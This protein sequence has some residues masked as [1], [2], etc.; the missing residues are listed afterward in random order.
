[1]ASEV[2]IRPGHPNE[3]GTLSALME[4]AIRDG[5]P[6]YGEAERAAWLGGPQAATPRAQRIAAQFV[7][8][9]DAPGDGPVGFMTMIP[10]GEIDFAYILPRWQ[11]R[12]LFPRLYAALEA[13]ARGLGLR[14]LVVY[15]SLM[16]DGPFARAGFALEREDPVQI[17][18]VELKRWLMRKSL[19]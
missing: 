19:T 14:E 10:D 6:A 17:G 12:G 9:A 16:A 7:W 1:M 4:T 8:V 15:A 13:H 11:G 5:A 18:G 2:Q 3:A